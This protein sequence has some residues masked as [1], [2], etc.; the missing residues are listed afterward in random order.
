MEARQGGK[1][2][3]WRALGAL[4]PDTPLEDIRFI[5]DVT[6]DALDGVFPDG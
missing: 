2:L 4:E 3:L 1:G 5:N 6:I